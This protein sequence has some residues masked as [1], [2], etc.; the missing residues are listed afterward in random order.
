MLRDLDH[1]HARERPNNRIGVQG[2][3][4]NHGKK[5]NYADL[6]N[7]IHNEKKLIP[8]EDTSIETRQ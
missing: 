7:G 4:D 2:D 6:A 8:L 3:Y 5:G 1:S